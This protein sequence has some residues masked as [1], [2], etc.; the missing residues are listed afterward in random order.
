[1]SDVHLIGNSAT[2][3]S[4][5]AKDLVILSLTQLKEIDTNG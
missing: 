3:Q 2:V 5:T 1:M 4:S